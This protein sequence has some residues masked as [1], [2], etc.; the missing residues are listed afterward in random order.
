MKRSFQE[1]ETL[2]AS[3]LSEPMSTTT[4]ASLKLKGTT[5]SSF[6]PTYEEEKQ[7]KE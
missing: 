7:H 2:A 3:S 5:T 4:N 1:E 6:G